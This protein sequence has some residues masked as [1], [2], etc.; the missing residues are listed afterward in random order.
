ME[1]AGPLTI[2]GKL[3]FAILSGSTVFISQALTNFLGRTP[4]QPE[5][6]EAEGAFRTTLNELMSAGQQALPDS[7]YATGVVASSV[8][9]IPAVIG[10]VGGTN[11]LVPAAANAAA[12]GKYL[13]HLVYNLCVVGGFKGAM[14][15]KALAVFGFGKIMR[16][17]LPQTVQDLGAATASLPS[18][19]AAFKDFFNTASSTMGGPEPFAS[20]SWYDRMPSMISMANMG[21]GYAIANPWT[22]A[23]A[24]ATGAATGATALY[25]AYKYLRPATAKQTATGSGKRDVTETLPGVAPSPYDRPPT[26]P[27]L[28]DRYKMGEVGDFAKGTLLESLYT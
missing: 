19:W 12:I 9:G 13:A 1:P 20:S 3:L 15:L 23:T 16:D 25:S 11:A 6:V 18:L 2:G 5:V 10:A 22:T 14:A 8:V 28:R 27:K 21:V 4:T 26:R 17:G 7:M 24:V